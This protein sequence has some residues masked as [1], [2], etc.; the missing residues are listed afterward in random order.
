MPSSTTT[1]SAA[2]TTYTTI[3][4]SGSDVI[5][6]SIQNLY[7]FLSKTRPWPEF[8]AGANAVDIPTSLSD[9]GIRI[10]RNLNYFSVNYAIIIS[11]FAAGSLIGSPVLLIFTCLIFASWL[12]LFFFREDPMVVFGH[13]VSDLIVIVGLLTVSAITIWFTGILNNLMVGIG[14]G[15]LVSVIH[16]SLRNPEGLFVDEDDAVTA[17]LIS[18]AERGTA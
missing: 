16:G 5:N 11:A 13:Q 10:R 7:T 18:N 8:L 14:I 1:S 15:V 12:I 2:A 3:P 4:I 9:A 6:R 17:G